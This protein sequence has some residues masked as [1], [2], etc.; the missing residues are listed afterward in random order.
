[1]PV[2]S[3]DIIITDI[4]MPV[5]DGLEEARRI[6]ALER[7]DAKTI[8]IVAFSANAFSEDV[9]K[10]LAAGINEHMSKPIDV[11]KFWQKVSRYFN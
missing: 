1:M 5:M 11:D 6:R 3:F 7:E 9:E 4:R 10:S 2:G 8:P